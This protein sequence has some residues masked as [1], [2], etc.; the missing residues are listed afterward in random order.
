M[1]IPLNI[2]KKL[3]LRGKLR[4]KGCFAICLIF[5]ETPGS[6]AYKLVAFK[7]KQID[8]SALLERDALDLL[9]QGE[10]QGMMTLTKLRGSQRA[11]NQ[12]PGAI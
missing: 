10:W 8:C 5:Q 12:F 3:L 9:F 1:A 7:K 2:R 6:C 4:L 11:P